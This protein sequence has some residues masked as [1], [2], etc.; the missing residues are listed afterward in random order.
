MSYGVTPQ[1]F[2]RKPYS[3]IL[4]ELH[5]QAQSGDCFGPDIDLSDENYIGPE[6]KLKAWALDKQWQLAEEVYY[7]MDI[8]NA[9]GPALNR[10]MKLGLTEREDARYAL[11]NLLYSGD[12]GSPVPVGAQAETDQNVVYEVLVDQ[13]IGVS[14]QVTVQARCMVTGTIGNVPANTIT[15][16][17]TP[18]P[19]IDSV[20]NPSA[21]SGGRGVETEPEARER[22]RSTPA[23]SGSSLD[24]ILAKVGEIEDIEDFTGFENETNA[25]NEYGIPAGSI[26][27]IASGSTDEKIAQAIFAKKAGGI[28]TFGNTLRTVIDSQ[29]TS[30]PIYFTRP[31]AVDVY[32]KFSLLTNDD[33]DV[34]QE[35]I[36]KQ[37]AVDHVNALRT[38]RAAYDWKISALLASTVGLEHVTVYLGTDPE[39]ITLDKIEVTIRQKLQTDL[40]KV[41]I[42]YE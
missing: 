33:W 35:A 42:E 31:V 16:L 32:V 8:D 12:E 10:L 23:S 38:G 25:E 11:V 13:V 37:Y 29:G 28:G 20:T 30:K 2:I 1:G 4:A 40:E 19:G 34:S 27:I 6:L 36:V 9:E 22:Y 15:K 5:A 21:A 39:N 24:A 3:V 41:S 14:G 18:L 26:E 7:S 17:K